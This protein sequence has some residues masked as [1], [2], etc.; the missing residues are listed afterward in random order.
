MYIR[1]FFVERRVIII[2]KRILKEPERGQYEILFKHF[3]NFRHMTQEELAFLVKIAPSYLS[4]F[5]QNNTT[6]TRSPKLN[7]I[8]DVAFALNVCPNDII[9]F[10]CKTCE[11]KDSCVRKKQVIDDDHNFENIINYYLE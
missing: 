6:R 10:P 4:M 11:M 2:N 5:E 8:R 3:R 9:Y 1:A 7:L